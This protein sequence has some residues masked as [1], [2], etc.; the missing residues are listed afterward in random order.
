MRRLVQSLALLVLLAS[1]PTAHAEEFFFKDGDRVVVIGD[2]ITEQHLYSNYVELWTVTRFPAWDVT[3]RN[4]GIGGDRST[5]GNSR[6]KRDVLPYKPTAMTVDFGMNDGNYRAFDEPGFKA[7][8]GGL[9][10]MA[11]QAKA[12]G[13]RVAWVTPQPLDNG[14]QGPTALTAYNL[15]LEKYS[16]GVGD[17]AQK[18]GGRFVDQFHPYL[19]VLDKA[20]GAAPKYDRITGGDAVHPGP[21]GQSLMAAAILKGL[22][23]PALVSAV[24]IDLAAPDAAKTVNCKI[25][26]L[27]RDGGTVRFERLDGALPF[28]P[29]EAKSILKWAPLLEELNSYTLKVA[30]LQGDKYEVRLGGK[31]IAEYSG[32]EL[33]KGVNLAQGALSA[34][35][36]AEQI[37]AVRAAVE[38]KNK[39][40]H[41][42]I[43]AGVVRAQV[44][45]PDW[46]GVKLTAE[47]IEAK[48]KAAY[49]ERMAKMPELDAA[50][51]K[52]LE[53]KPHQVEIVVVETKEQEAS[54]KAL[55]AVWAEVGTPPLRPG[56]EVEALPAAPVFA[57]EKLKDF[58]VGGADSDLRKAVRKGRA[59]VWAV[60][61]EAGG[62]P[63]D[64]LTEVQQ[65]RQA[66]GLG[67]MILKDGVRAPANEN[68]FKAMLVLRQRE[69]ARAMTVLTDIHEEL[70]AV[71][72]KRAKETK[73][74]QANYD[75]VKARLE[76]QIAFL[77]EYQ[78]ALG[79]MRRELQP[80][81]PATQSGWVLEPKEQL[82]GDVSGRRLAKSAVQTLDYIITE[83]N[84]TPWEVLARR[85]KDRLIGLDWKAVP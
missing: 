29:D 62:G 39:F 74:W 31:K 19:A 46:V 84:G 6:F 17:I 47:E 52:A 36:V 49:T 67:L 68:Q 60:A 20:R 30:G 32:A 51:R 41:D 59:A 10:G 75:L 73:R 26:G 57:P 43:F 25:S 38:A 4:V 42:R 77:Y 58:A 24:S 14:D 15:T 33:A 37:K 5:G 70:I 64:S 63:A 21:P 40:H 79:L 83:Y 76:M 69:I 2:S 80:L 85:E 22:N 3:F 55:E 16:A 44:T 11:D 8:M 27:K 18:N 53:M 23:F 56:K 50:V 13:I 71:G 9:Q 54:R 78:S 65:L 35:P 7:Y 28:F 1:A 72:D 34:G 66:A 45:I 48:R 82:K 12:A 61:A 81:D